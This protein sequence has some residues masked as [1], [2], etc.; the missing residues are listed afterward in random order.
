MIFSLKCLA[1]FERLRN[2]SQLQFEQ[3]Q[4]YRIIKHASDSDSFCESSAA[5]IATMKVTERLFHCKIICKLR[6]VSRMSII[7]DFSE[8]CNSAVGDIALHAFAF[9]CLH[10]VL[11]LISFFR[12]PSL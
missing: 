11:F 6:S 12:F 10:K 4:M 9:K 8:L 5:F 3:N 7:K 1:E 2:I